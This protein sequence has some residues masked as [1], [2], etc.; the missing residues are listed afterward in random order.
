VATCSIPQFFAP[1]RAW[2]HAIASVWIASCENFIDRKNLSRFIK[3][4]PPLRGFLL[5]A[6]LSSTFLLDRCLMR[7]GPLLVQSKR[8]GIKERYTEAVEVQM[9]P[10]SFDVVSSFRQKRK[11]QDIVSSAGHTTRR[12]TGMETCDL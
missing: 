10:K 9:Q 4:H 5:K 12:L 3:P 1:V 8:I 2:I 11:R 6:I 7:F